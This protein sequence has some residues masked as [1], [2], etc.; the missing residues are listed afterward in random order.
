MFISLSNGLCL[1]P[2]APPPPLPLSP[3][4]SSALVNIHFEEASDRT[5]LS[6]C[7]LPV[8][9][10]C[11][12]VSSSVCGLCL[13]VSFCPPPS[14]RLCVSVCVSVSLCLC[15][16][17]SVSICLCLSLSLCAIQASV[18]P[19]FFCSSQPT[20]RRR[21]RQGC[22]FARQEICF[23]GSSRQHEG[24]FEEAV[25]QAWNV[26]TGCNGVVIG[27]GR[28]THH[29]HDIWEWENG[30]VV[31]GWVGGGGWGGGGEGSI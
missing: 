25:W 2:Y 16:S 20:R 28:Q 22:D 8:L 18:S 9:S 12:F 6:L 30:K 26:C 15:L 3:S 4:L 14:S 23:R 10:L 24:S 11:L 29:I 13:S 19:I 31:G 5:V 27:V 21:L 7:L 17:V 1:S